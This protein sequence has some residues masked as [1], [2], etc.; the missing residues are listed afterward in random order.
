MSHQVAEVV[1]HC[2]WTS[3]LVAVHSLSPC[4]MNCEFLQAACLVTLL[5][6]VSNSPANTLFVLGLYS[7]GK[8][9]LALAVAEARQC[10][11]FCTDEKRRQVERHSALPVA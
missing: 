4:M 5:N 8:E 2:M 10:Q 9:Q 7:T 11:V 1:V 6:L 3:S